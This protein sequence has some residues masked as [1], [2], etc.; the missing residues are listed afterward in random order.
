MRR[1]GMPYICTRS[2]MSGAIAH[3]V[4][5]RRTTR[6]WSCCASVANASHHIR[7]HSWRRNGCG[8]A[9]RSTASFH[10]P[11]IARNVALSETRSTEYMSEP[12]GG[13]PL[14][15]REKVEVQR[16]GSA[17]HLLDRVTIFDSLAC[18]STESPGE[19][20]I[21]QQ[22]GNGIGQGRRIARFNEQAGDIVDDRLRRAAYARCDGGCTGRH[23]L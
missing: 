1:T 7:T 18:G 23:R 22:P 14:F 3:T 9:A 12:R 20:R 17:D 13:S 16:F 19:R 6:M 21:L 11:S 15:A 10:S 5:P 2:N 8:T 4:E